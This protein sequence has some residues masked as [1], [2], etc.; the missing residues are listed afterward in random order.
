MRQLLSQS[1]RPSRVV[2]ALRWRHL[3]EDDSEV[4]AT[5]PVNSGRSLD[6][7]KS[8]HFMV[9]E[10]GSLCFRS[11]RIGSPEVMLRMNSVMESVD[12]LA[13]RINHD[14]F[15][16]NRS[17]DERWSLSAAPET[18]VAAGRRCL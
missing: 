8:L 18:A 3:N 11:T 2:G 4:S 7:M 9:T 12:F 6:P 14:T 17:S 13:V 5:C 1:N 15:S 10:N 16:D